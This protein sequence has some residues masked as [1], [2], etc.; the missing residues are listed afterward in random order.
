MRYVADFPFESANAIT[1]QRVPP[2][3]VKAS[4]VRQKWEA[5]K[6]RTC[7]VTVLHGKVHVV[8]RGAASN[9]LEVCVRMVKMS[10]NTGRN[11]SVT[12]FLLINLS[13][14]GLS[15]Q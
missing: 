10:S 5:C 1:L 8:G 13:I 4:R 2:N 12:Y 11:G 9:W 7:N 14:V 3:L 15:V 6:L